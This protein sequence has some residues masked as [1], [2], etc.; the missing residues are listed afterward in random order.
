M[1][2]IHLKLREAAKLDLQAVKVLNENN[3]YAPAI[4][5]CAQA[6]EKCSK[7]IQAYYEM[8]IN[9]IPTQDIGDKLRK[10]YSHNLDK[11]RR[12]IM[13][14]LTQMD[15]QSGGRP[16]LTEKELQKLF[17]LQPIRTDIQR[18]VRKFDNISDIA[19][20]RYCAITNKSDRGYNRYRSIQRLQ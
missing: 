16:I 5:H 15:R 4:Y 7:S 10:S 11:S 12:T 13:E 14:F 8:K 9:K 17:Y 19:Y 20:E 18:F 3:L 2:K 6:V 1:C